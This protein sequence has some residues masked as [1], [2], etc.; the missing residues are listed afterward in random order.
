[1]RVGIIKGNFESQDSTSRVFY[2]TFGIESLNRW[3]QVG[4]DRIRY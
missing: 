4:E 1:M 3:I 2:I